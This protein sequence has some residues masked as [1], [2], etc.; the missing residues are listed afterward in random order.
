MQYEQFAM[1]M[2]IGRFVCYLSFDA[3]LLCDISVALLFSQKHL[4]CFLVSKNMATW[5]IFDFI[6]LK[7]H[8]A[9]NW[10]GKPTNGFYGRCI[11]CFD[12]VI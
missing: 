6:V 7:D 5:V 12:M 2:K 9:H 3:T 10:I 1:C 8:L 11:M 4:S